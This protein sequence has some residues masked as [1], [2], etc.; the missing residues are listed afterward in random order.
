MQHTAHF[1]AYFNMLTWPDSE[2]LPSS[3]WFWF[4]ESVIGTRHLLLITYFPVLCNLVIQHSF[5]SHNVTLNHK[6][7]QPIVI[8]WH[9]PLL[10]AID[11]IFFSSYASTKAYLK[12]YSI[13][14]FFYATHISGGGIFDYC[15]RFAIFI[16]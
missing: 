7:M 6:C 11:V 4:I 5:P 13:T 1:K 12:S 9:D 14:V 3:S 16:Y 2:N 8:V 10:L 15:N